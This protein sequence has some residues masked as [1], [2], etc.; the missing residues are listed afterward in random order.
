MQR[1]AGHN[2]K[3]MPHIPEGLGQRWL[4]GTFLVFREHML[5]EVAGPHTSAS[6]CSPSR[7]PM[8]RVCRGQLAFICVY[9]DNGWM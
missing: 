1:A 9:L 8:Q 6:T 5:L 3:T 7:M 2:P 4:P